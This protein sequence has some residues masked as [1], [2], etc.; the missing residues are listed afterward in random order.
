MACDHFGFSE[1]WKESS[2]GWNPAEPGLILGSLKF[3]I[4]VSWGKFLNLSK[5]AIPKKVEIMGQTLQC[6]E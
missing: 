5:P 4:H 3:A 2:E 1:R 6:K